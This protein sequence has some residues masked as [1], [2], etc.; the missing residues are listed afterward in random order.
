M[1]HIFKYNTIQYNTN[2]LTLYN[3]SSQKTRHTVKT[4][5]ILGY[6]KRNVMS[7]N[8]FINNNCPKFIRFLSA[9]YMN[10]DKCLARSRKS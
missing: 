8:T 1:M 6:Q 10:F 4:S 2:I 5:T 9:K 3:V 7:I